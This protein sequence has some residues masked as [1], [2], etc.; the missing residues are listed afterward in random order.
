MKIIDKNEIAKMSK[1]PRLNLINSITGYK[2]ANL[3][4]TRSSSGISNVAIFS[5][6][7]H[8][9][10]N[11][12]LI[13][14]IVRPTTVPRHT[15]QNLKETGHFT[16]NHI[17]VDIIK[18]AHYTSANFDEGI[19]EFDKTNLTPHYI[20]GHYEPFVEESPIK[21]YC[22]YLNEYEIKENG[23][24]HVIATIEKIILNSA[25]EE[26]CWVR[27]DKEKIVAINGLD[28][29]ALPILIDRFEYAKPDEELTSKL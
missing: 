14:F 20:D 2:S 27:L 8:L 22:K 4:G 19:S 6:V 3:I 13:G 23:C 11:P 17:T 24:I 15:Y 25:I 1:I 9:G 28:G 29:Y 26:D 21:L 12:A 5:S 10:S 18:K 7:T 16:I